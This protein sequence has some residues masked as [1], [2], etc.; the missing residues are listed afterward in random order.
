M[1]HRSVS[2]SELPVSPHLTDRERQVLK[3][4]AE[5]WHN[6]GIA[7]AI[8]R[9]IKTVQKHRQSVNNKLNLHDPAGLTRYAVST[10]LTRPQRITNACS[11]RVAHLTRRQKQVLKLIAMGVPNK[12]IAYELHISINTVCNHRESL[13]A[14]LGVHEIAGVTRYAVALGLVPKIEIG[15][16]EQTEAREAC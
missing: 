7:L 11:A 13:M 1:N 14:R 2:R 16:E 15:K 6:S 10:G 4:I 9:S 8:H 12:G 3:F 5:G